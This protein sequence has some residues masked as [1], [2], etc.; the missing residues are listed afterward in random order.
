MK[1]NLVNIY[2]LLW[3]RAEKPEMKDKFCC[4]LVAHASHCTWKHTM[5]LI[6]I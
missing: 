5:L 6:S 1:V 4:P 3:L 2:L